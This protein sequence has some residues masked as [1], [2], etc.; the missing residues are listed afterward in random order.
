MGYGANILLNSSAEAGNLNDWTT[1]GVTIVANT[2]PDYILRPIVDDRD[3]A[4]DR[5]EPYGSGATG[6]HHFLLAATASM[7][8]DVAASGVLNYQLEAVF[9]IPTSQDA[10]DSDILGWV[11]MSFT[12]SDGSTD[13]FMIPCVL[14]VTYSGRTIANFWLYAV[15]ECPVDTDKTLTNIRVHIETTTLIGGLM[16]DYLTL[17]EE[18]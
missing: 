16:I 3:Q 7:Y 14:G 11:L 9:Q 17:K 10:W 13:R 6:T 2:A 18:T 12:Y 15:R 4:F 1:S 5:G 8:Q